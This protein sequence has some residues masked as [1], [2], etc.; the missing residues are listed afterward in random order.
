MP[1]NNKGPNYDWIAKQLKNGR[2]VP[3]L[4][5]GASISCG[6]PSGSK[7]AEI[8]VKEGKFPG[9]EGRDNLALVASYLA[10]ISGDSNLLGDLLRT[11][12]CIEVNP[13]ALHQCLASIDR[14]ELI[15]TTNYDDLMEQALKTRHP[16]IVVDR[17]T[18]GNVWLR[19]MNTEWRAVEANTLR[20]SVAE[21]NA[22]LVRERTNEILEQM[23][24][25][26]ITEAQAK[27][28]REQI[29]G[30]KP[31]IFKM[32]GSFDRADW[33]HD[34]FLITEEHYV[35]FL[36][37]P[38]KGQVPQMLELMMQRQNFLFLGYGLKDWNVRVMLRKLMLMRSP[39]DHIISW[40][41]VREA[42]ASEKKLWRAHGVQMYEV[43][44]D[45]F[46][47]QLQARL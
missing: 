33:R 1:S 29:N 43:D 41:I 23:V 24:K 2:V 19:S 36:G 5:A 6:L 42:S 18:S 39:A 38:Q 15:V 9:R 46:S 34:A 10:Q 14:L 13:G 28:A 26:E 17:G 40:A 37:R 4:G 35:D 3:F 30:P 47:K 31:I 16:W 44:L 7:L 22:K 12:L 8:L 45:D 20:E 11:Q 32:H 21:L 25:T 27:I